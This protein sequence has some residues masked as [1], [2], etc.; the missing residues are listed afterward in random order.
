MTPD[1]DPYIDFPE[2]DAEDHHPRR[3]RRGKERRRPR[4]S[5]E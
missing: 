5:S 4:D 1:P 3:V 2:P